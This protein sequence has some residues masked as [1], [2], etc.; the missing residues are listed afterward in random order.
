MVGGGGVGGGGVNGGVGLRGGERGYMGLVGR[1]YGVIV[2][3]MTSYDAN[4]LQVH[5][6]ELSCYFNTSCHARICTQ[7]LYTCHSTGSCC[8]IANYSIVAM[9]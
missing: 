5:E 3:Y 7:S 1:D 8:N 2:R 9:L 4:R 6:P